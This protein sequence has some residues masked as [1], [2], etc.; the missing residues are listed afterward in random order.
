MSS[1]ST[2]N[3]LTGVT[4]YLTGTSYI[5]IG[6]Q[7]VVKLKAP[8]SGTY[9]GMVIIQDKTSNVGVENK[10]SSGGNVDIE[11]AVYM[12]KQK[13]TV[14]ASGDMNVNSKYFPIIADK[15]EMGGNGTLHV[16]LDWAGAGFPEPTALA[17][18]GYLLLSQ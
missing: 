15:F 13:L 6:S 18:K 7:G 11:G 1:D 12:P 4:F 16:N 17:T 3:G 2:L 5:D 10:I 14:W 9:A 8:T